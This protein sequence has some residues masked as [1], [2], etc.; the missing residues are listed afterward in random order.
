M[1][2]IHLLADPAAVAH[3][4]AEATVTHLT[5]A[6]ADAGTATW[7]LTG[8][9]SPLAAYRILAETHPDSL[10]WGSVWLAIGDERCVPAD[11]P[12]SN[13]GQV[14]RTLLEHV[15]FA[16]YRTLHPEGELGPTAAAA[17]YEQRL[18]DL[19]GGTTGAPTLDLV[20]LG[21]GEDGHTLSLFPGR[22]EA[23]VVDRLVIGVHDSPKPPPER[24]SLTLGALRGTRRCLIL[25]AGA[26]KAAVLGRATSGDLDLPVAR[27]AAEIE[28]AGG[29]V[30]WLLDEAA[31]AE[32][33]R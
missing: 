5:A 11:H 24:I 10:D 28:A 6:L 19:P 31:G 1:A 32:V 3:A 13:W 9:T 30:T 33:T 21:V 16:E 12:A 15:P 22:P 8:G 20:W 2:D 23:G 25:G 4:A 7:V 29:R 17:R 26:A 27:A 18:L 14:R